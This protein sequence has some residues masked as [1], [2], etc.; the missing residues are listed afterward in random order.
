M[1]TMN[2]LYVQY[3]SERK[4]AHLESHELG[5][6]FVHPSIDKH[7]RGNCVIDTRGSY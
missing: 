6:Y 1:S 5:L 4:F 2:R 3:N 7:E